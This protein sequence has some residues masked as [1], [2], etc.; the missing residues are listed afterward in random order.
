MAYLH[1]CK[2]SL[3]PSVPSHNATANE[4]PHSYLSG[5]LPPDPPAWRQTGCQRGEPPLGLLLRTSW[6]L[7]GFPR[8]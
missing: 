7:N 8:L 5:E 1:R 4:Y 3:K 6:S 2:P